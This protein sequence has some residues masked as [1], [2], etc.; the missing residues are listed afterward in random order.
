MSSINAQMRYQV[1]DQQ[2]RSNPIN[3]WKDLSE[4][5]ALFASEWD[6]N[7]SP[8]SKRTI[9][10][11]IQRMR[12]GILGYQAPIAYSKERGYYYTNKKFSIFKVPLSKISTDR[13]SDAL[14]MLKQLT[15]NENFLDIHHTLSVLEDRL[16]LR[17]DLNNQPSIYLEHSL[18]EAGQRWLDTVYRYIKSQQPIRVNYTPFEGEPDEH[19]VSPV[20]IR[21]YNHRWYLYGYLH[22][23]EVIINLAL[24]RITA[25]QPSLISYYVPEDFNHDSWFKNM[26]GVTRIPDAEVQHIEFEVTPLLS[27]YMISKP[28]H[29]TQRLVSRRDDMVCFSIDVYI[30]YE[31]IHRLL[32]F[33]VDLVVTKPD[34]LIEIMAEK[35]SIMAGFY[36]GKST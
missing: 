2:L 9:A 31:I 27:K 21:E 17:I 24:D 1:I 23:K 8:P 12:S 18:N 20:F 22:S 25:I 34:E 5:C 16:Q 3:H 15:K 28:L 35:T 29:P 14:L 4:A 11:D 36:S 33:G 26:Y 10:Y 32:G 6:K 7:T 30:T 13:V 19:I